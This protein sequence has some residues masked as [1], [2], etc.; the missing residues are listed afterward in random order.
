MCGTANFSGIISGRGGGTRTVSGTQTLSGCGND[1]TGVTTMSGGALSVDCLLDGGLAS[2]VGASP[3][4]A[5]NL[6]IQ[7]NGQLIYTG[8]SVSIDRGFR[9][10]SGNG[11]LNVNAGTTLEFEGQVTGGGTRSEEHTSELQSLMRISYAVFCLQK[12]NKK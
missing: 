4:D 6:V 7:S 11:Y 12:K 10:A 2:A 9:L 8:P 3:A 5:S 1:Y